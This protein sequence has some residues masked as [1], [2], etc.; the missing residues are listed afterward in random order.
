M[1]LQFDMSKG[2]WQKDYLDQKQMQQY[3]E[4]LGTAL[5][6]VIDKKI[7]Q[8]LLAGALAKTGGI[9]GDGIEGG[10]KAAGKIKD[11]AGKVKPGLIG[12]K[13]T[14]DYFEGPQDSWLMSKFKKSK[15]ARNAF[16]DLFIGDKDMLD[17]FEGS[18][19]SPL[20]GL[21]KSSLKRRKMNKTPYIDELLEY[22]PPVSMPVT[23]DNI[24]EDELQKNYGPLQGLVEQNQA[25]PLPVIQDEVQNEIDVPVNNAMLQMMLDRAINQRKVAPMT[26]EQRI[27]EMYR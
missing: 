18:Q 8:S 15:N 13:D 14:A 17:Q 12:D 21:I 16:K 1:A 2:N 3:A 19:D 10:E 23:P 11:I 24:I 6:L 22:E 9:I 5:G 25:K 27:M 4:N 7:P 26:R 20:M